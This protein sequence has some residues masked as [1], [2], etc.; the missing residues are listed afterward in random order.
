MDLLED[1]GNSIS[2]DIDIGQIEGSFV[3]GMGYYT[4]EE[5]Q[6]STKSGRLLNNKSWVIIKY[7]L[8]TFIEEIK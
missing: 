6:Y 8:I 5:L 3:M 2:P 1:N 7:L 4:C